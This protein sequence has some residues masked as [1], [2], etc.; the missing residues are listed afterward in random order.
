MD[1]VVTL[2]DWVIPVSSVLISVWFAASAKKDADNAN[3]LQKQVSEAINGWQDN[4]NKAV[5]EQLLTSPQIIE[6]KQK[7]AEIQ[8]RQKATD[9]LLE[10]LKNADGSP[11]ENQERLKQMGEIAKG[12]LHREGSIDK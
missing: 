11:F 12:I 3:E 4:L 8:I 6:G 2:K 7:L 10:A 9:V 1:F 5:F